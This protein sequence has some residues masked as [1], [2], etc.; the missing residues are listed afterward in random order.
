M[1][2]ARASSGLGIFTAVVRVHHW[3][4]LTALGNPLKFPISSNPG[5][6]GGVRQRRSLPC[7]EDKGG[8]VIMRL[9]ARVV[10]AAA[11][12]LMLS[13]TGVLI[14]A[15]QAEAAGV[16]TVTPSTDLSGGQVVSVSGAG[17]ADSSEGSIVECSNVPGQPTVTVLGNAVPV[18]CTNPL[19]HVTSTTSSGDLAATN[20]TIVQGTVG[21]PGSGN[22][23]N[24]V[25]GATDAASYPCPPTPTQVSDG[26][27]CT[28]SFGDLANDEA[29]QEL[30][31]STSG[32]VTTTT[33]STTTTTTT[34]PS[35][36]TTTTTTVPNAPADSPS[37]S[38]ACTADSSP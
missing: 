1:R 21:P 3:Y 18:S 36:G 37:Y 6:F 10:V 38:L 33:S 14:L 20:F 31:F 28:I 13:G 27:Y 16:L 24:G 12:M 25:S 34:S 30:A 9:R 15:A 2:P 35:S 26:Y 29:S 19:G 11:V 8:W 7:Q 23:S 17:F 22:D 4:C 5:A 32:E